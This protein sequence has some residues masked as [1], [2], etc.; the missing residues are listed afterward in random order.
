M[1]NNDIQKQLIKLRR[2]KKIL[3]LGILFLVLVIFWILVSIFATTKTSVISPELREL[4]KPFISRLESKVF[5][6]ILTQQ[7]FSEEELSSFPIFI[8]DQTV[9]D[10]NKLINIIHEET[11]SSSMPGN[12]TSFWENDL[13]D[14]SEEQEASEAANI[15]SVPALRD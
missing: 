10:D 1:N 9:Y 13:V 15:V 6:E 2:N 11:E 12:N 14:S 8:L 3:W 4:S 7:I 5:D